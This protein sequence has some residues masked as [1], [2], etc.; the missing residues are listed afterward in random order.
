MG[1]A[2]RRRSELKNARES[3]TN[4]F[5]LA[6]SKNA[7][8]AWERFLM[9]FPKGQLAILAEDRLE[10]MR[11]IAKEKEDNSYG[12]ATRAATVEEYDR[13]LHE[14]PTGRYSDE[15]KKKR[16]D[17]ARRIAE[18]NARLAELAAYTAA[19]TGDTIASWGAYLE[20]YPKALHTEEA[21]KRTEQLKWIEFAGVSA[22]PG[23]AFSMG[24]EKSGDEKPVHRVEVDGFMLMKG[25]VTNAQYAKFV[26]ET[27]HRR[28]TDPGWAKGYFASNPDLPVV[29]VAYDDAVAF[30]KWLSQKTG[31][32][33]RLPTE[34]EW[35]YAA[36]GGKD[37]QVYP[38]GFEKPRLKARYNGNTGQGPKTAA[39][40]AYAAGPFGL[41]NMS[42]NAAEWVQDYYG[43]QY[44]RGS[45]RK[46]P[47][48]PPSGMERV[49]R[50]GSY[51][52][53]EDEVRCAAREKR[54]P[55]EPGE[56][57]GFRALIELPKK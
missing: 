1:E 46:N 36:T 10:T 27:N 13:Y 33:V 25:E 3:E 38:W 53:G 51:K 34:A 57:A 4:A 44:Y 47:T 26:A 23:G 6:E 9:E 15:V 37:N 20:K 14:Y 5:R 48:G 28:P 24:S 45:P 32:V 31:A 50:G 29:G 7:E 18:E 22:I 8:I 11:R 2:E 55:A 35:E 16:D 12:R 56:D 42:G 41:F 19:K 30:C 40:N 39:A 52:T 54:K 49:L 21:Q 17:L 43:E